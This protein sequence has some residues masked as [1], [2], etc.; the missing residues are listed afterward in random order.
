MATI[1]GLTADVSRFYHPKR[2]SPEVGDVRVSF[3]CVHDGPASIMALQCAGKGPG[4]SFMPYR[5]VSRGF[6]G[7]PELALKSALLAQ[8]KKSP[9][10]LYEEDATSAFRA[11]VGQI[12]RGFRAVLL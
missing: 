8:G 3:E 2:P 9:D 1:Y 6:C 7:M 11:D 10:E 12:H 4:A 5:L